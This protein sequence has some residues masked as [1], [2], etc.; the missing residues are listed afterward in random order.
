MTSVSRCGRSTG[1]R[2]GARSAGAPV[3]RR[4]RRACGARRPRA[5][6]AAGASRLPD[7]VPVM[8]GRYGRRLRCPSPDFHWAEGGRA[9]AGRSAAPG[10][11]VTSR[12]AGHPRRVRQRRARGCPCPRSPSAPARPLTTAHRLLGELADWGALRPPRRRP[13]RDRPQALGPRPAGAGA[14]GAAPGRRALPAGRAHRHPRHRAPRRPRRAL[15][16]STSSGSPA[17]SRCRWSARWAA[18][19]RCTRPAWARCCSPRRRRTSS[20]RRC[21]R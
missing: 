1:V 7:V 11:S 10:R 5:G 8:P 13:L 19:C 18:G 16:R 14:A 4:S 15:A 3:V 9:M 12:G 21:A 6:S 20:S 2:S 17:A